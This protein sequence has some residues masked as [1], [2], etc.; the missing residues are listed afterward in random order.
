ML[1]SFTNTPAPAAPVEPSLCPEAQPPA[2][3]PAASRWAMTLARSLT[4]VGLLASGV[5]GLIHQS[6]TA[7]LKMCRSLT[8]TNCETV[9]VSQY[10]SILGV[11]LPVLG[12]VGF[13]VVL[14]LLLYPNSRAAILLTP[15]AAVAA[16]AGLVL[17]AIQFYVIG[18]H[19]NVC[20][21]ADVAAVGLGGL[22]L[23][24]GL[25]PRQ[26]VDDLPQATR[27]G[28]ALAAVVAVLLALPAWIIV[29][30]FSLCH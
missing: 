28:W 19:C 23:L 10:G 4:L 14:G 17:L 12:L 3:A 16:T 18:T 13:A 1:D 25:L 15:L 24:A 22:V 26:A 6:G 5:T 29:G 30:T 27:W 20:V 8:P 11:P 21:A 9:I 2:I 7:S